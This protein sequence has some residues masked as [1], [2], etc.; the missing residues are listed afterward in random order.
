MAFEKYSTEKLKKLNKILLA[1]SIV[2]LFAMCF[3]LGM[4]LYHISHQHESSLVYLVPTVFGPIT[5]IPIIF[6]A[7]ISSEIKKRKQQSQ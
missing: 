4:G 2:G 6:S 3:A 7:L 5:F 1:V